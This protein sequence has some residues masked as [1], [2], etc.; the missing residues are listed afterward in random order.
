[1]TNCSFGKAQIQGENSNQTNGAL[2]IVSK[3]PLT[4]NGAGGG[5]R[6]PTPIKARDPKSRMSANFITPAF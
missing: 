2:S 4:G 6:T 5:T 1:M 3:L